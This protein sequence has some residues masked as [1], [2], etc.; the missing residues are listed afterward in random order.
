MP[1]TQPRL[2]L[3]KE[4]IKLC[5]MDIWLENFYLRTRI[6]QMHSENC[7]NLDMNPQTQLFK[8]ANGQVGPISVTCNTARIICS[9]IWNL[10]IEF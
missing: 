9:D 8:A 3:D 6:R 7:L 5:K 4:Q 1:P 2:R 10:Y